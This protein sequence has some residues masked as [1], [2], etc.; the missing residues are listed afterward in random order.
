[1]A[2]AA[3]PLEDRFWEKVK[4]TDGCWIWTAARHWFGYGKFFIKKGQP[5][6]LAHRISYRLAFGEI[7]DGLQVLHHCD[8]PECVRPEHLFLGTQRDNMRDCRAKGRWKYKP[9]DQSGEQNPSSVISDARARL[10]LAEIDSGGRPV[11]T[12]RKYGIS[13]KTLWAIRHRKTTLR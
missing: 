9:R 8:V 3:R 11:A 10:M 12:A 1:M 5:L 2:Y 7:P 4:K 13:Y 6:Q